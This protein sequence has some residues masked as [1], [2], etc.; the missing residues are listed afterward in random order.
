MASGFSRSWS[1]AIKE[2]TMLIEVTEKEAMEIY[3]QRYVNLKR[4]LYLILLGVS[5]VVSIVVYYGILQVN[6]DFCLLACLIMIPALYASL[7]QSHNAGKY[8]KSMVNNP[9]DSA[10]VRSKRIKQ[11]M[12]EL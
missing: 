12:K 5:F 8:A 4:K 9:L 3:A 10:I 6:P 11:K 2:A 7:R 1:D